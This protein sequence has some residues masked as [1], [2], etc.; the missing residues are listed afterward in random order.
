MAKKEQKYRVLIL[1]GLGNGQIAQASEV[2]AK[3]LA[4]AFDMKQGD[5]DKLVSSGALE[6]IE[7]GPV[8]EIPAPEPEPKKAEA[9]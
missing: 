6:R 3:D 9:K 2:T 4:T 1:G 5:V 7:D 8:V